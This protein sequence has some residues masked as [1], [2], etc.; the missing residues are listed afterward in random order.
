[1]RTADVQFSIRGYYK[2]LK[3]G[4]IYMA[5]K[6]VTDCTNGREDDRLVIYRSA[7]KGPNDQIFA[8][9]LDEFTEKFDPISI[10]DLRRT[11]NSELDEDFNF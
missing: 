6:I 10:Y 2:H 1:M 9:R 7:W 5:S 3:T 4:N 8:R 11:I